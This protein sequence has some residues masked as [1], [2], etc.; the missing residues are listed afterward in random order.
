M[1][2]WCW[3]KAAPGWPPACS[4]PIWWIALL[5]YRAPI[6][7]G[8]RAALRDIGLADLAGRM[9]AGQRSRSL[10]S[11]PTGLRRYIRIR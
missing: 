10:R 8:G 7:I 3:P 11:V 6:L 5:L 9:A 2:I 4:P 1:P